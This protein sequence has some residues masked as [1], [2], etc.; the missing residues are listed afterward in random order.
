MQKTLQGS[1]PVRRVNRSGSKEKRVGISRPPAGRVSRRAHVFR[2]SH[3]DALISTAG[4]RAG[5]IKGID[6]SYPRLRADYRRFLDG[7]RLIREFRQ[8]CG[9]KSKV[10]SISTAGIHLVYPV[11]FPG[12]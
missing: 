7:H 4:G 10:Y 6:N 5:E 11:A 12:S 8:I 1:L 3:E 9:C 2:R